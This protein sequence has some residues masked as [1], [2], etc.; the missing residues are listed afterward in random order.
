MEKYFQLNKIAREMTL[1]HLRIN[2]NEGVLDLSQKMVSNVFSAFKKSSFDY[3]PAKHRKISAVKSSLKEIGGSSTLKNLFAKMKEQFSDSE[4]SNSKYSNAKSLYGDFMNKGMDALNRMVEIDPKLESKIIKN[5]QDVFSGYTSKM[6]EESSRET[7]INESENSPI[8]KESVRRTKEKLEK[9]LIPESAGKT[10]DNGYGRA[11]TRIFSDLDQRLS[12]ILEDGEISGDSER[13]AFKTIQSQVEKLSKEFYSYCIKATE[14]S[15]KKINSDEETAKKFKDIEDMVM[16]QMS[17]LARANAEEENAENKI[18]QEEEEA[19]NKITAKIFPLKQGDND[20]SKRLKDSGIIKAVQKAL[21]NSFDSVKDLLGKSGGSDGVFTPQLE[22]AVK[23]I[24]SVMGNKNVSGQ[25]DRPMLDL[26]LNA[27]SVSSKDKERIS[28]SLDVLRDE[29]IGE[30]AKNIGEKPSHKGFM[31]LKQFLGEEAIVE[32]TIHIDNEKLKDEIEKLSIELPEQ[33]KSAKKGPA[34]T[35]SDANFESKASLLAKLLRQKGMCKDAEDERFVRED[36]TLKS[37]YT[38]E[39]IDA[40]IKVAEESDMNSAPSYFLVEYDGNSIDGL[41][42]SKRLSSTAKK[43]CNWPKWKQIIGEYDSSD[44]FDF[45]KWYSGYYS[46]LGGLSAKDRYALAK[47]I[48]K[49]N[50][51]KGDEHEKIYDKLYKP[52]SSESYYYGF[53]NEKGMETIVNAFT[54]ACQIDEK[55]KDMKDSDFALLANLVALTSTAFMYD[56]EAEEF[57]SVIE[58]I[59]KKVL[60]PSVMDAITSDKVIDKTK[61]SYIELSKEGIAKASS[62]DSAKAIFKKN[63]NRAKEVHLPPLRTHLSRM[64]AKTSEDLTRD[65]RKG[66]FVPR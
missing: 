38:P 65:A 41:Y 28:K 64:N 12:A 46:N 13:K 17:I 45:V 35:T 16:D 1:E 53:I 4:I 14:G 22:I 55:E 24:Q 8:S 43:P 2:E 3:A 50:G 44:L 42:A 19:E 63:L 61:D 57:V 6:K 40:W 23:S 52:F 7:S 29:Y 5:F 33:E 66:V 62:K 10:P 56:K 36:G 49:E 18:K 9:I 30:S 25:I 48:A 31:S 39:F 51:E 26:I 59:S 27:D 32:S 54:R 47:E 20:D 58:H 21:I 11:W 60:S 15:F 34:G 37:S